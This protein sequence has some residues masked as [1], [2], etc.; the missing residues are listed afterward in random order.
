MADVQQA[1]FKNFLGG[2]AQKMAEE[3]EQ[4]LRSRAQ[5]PHGSDI[6]QHGA[7]LLKAQRKLVTSKDLG[8][9][10]MRIASKLEQIRRT[11]AS[12]PDVKQFQQ[13]ME[14]VR[15]LLR[16]LVRSEQFRSTLIAALK[17]GKHIIEENAEGS[18][19]K[20]LE[21]G[22][23]KGF[24]AAAKEAKSA[25]DK[26]ARNLEKKTDKDRDLISD[27]DWEKLTDE[28]DSLFSRL[29]S[30]SEFRNGIEQLFSLGSMITSEAKKQKD[31]ISSNAVQE[32]KEEAKDLV[33]Q[34]SG[35]KE[36][37]KLFDSLHS[38]VKEFDS[39]K[40]A[41][42]WWNEFKDHT[43]K[44]AKNYHGKDDLNKFRDL[45]QRGLDIFR[46]VRPKLDKLFDRMSDVLNNIANDEYVLK[47]RESLGAISDD[48]Y[49]QDKEGK[50]YIDGDAAGVLLS[51]VS[52]VI[53]NKF[54]HLPLPRI[55]RVEDDMAYTLD[56]LIISATLP[57]QIDFHL[58]SYASVN[59]S[60]M[61]IPGQSSLQTEIYLT[62]AI[63]GIT[64]VAPNIRFTYQGTALSES[65]IMSVR[66]PEPGAD[67]TLEFVMRP[68]SGSEISAIKAPTK[69]ETTTDTSK[70]GFATA[71]GGGMMRYE[72]VKVVSHFDIPDLDIDYDTKTL[73]HSFLVPLITS[74]FKARIV[75]RFED[76]VEQALNKGLETLGQNLVSILNKAEN[77]LSISSVGSS[78]GSSMFTAI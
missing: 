60:Q 36:L 8:D 70:K 15:P 24:E 57:D 22:E 69:I 1:A 7:D 31:A 13:Q 48:L 27:R 59:T 74:L 12:S 32:V 61:G 18:V 72:F 63:R 25:I 67:L 40:E 78:V 66:I 34:F 47:L 49:W 62:A 16:L 50:R 5:G 4:E 54:G 55:Q 76:E 37:D 20:I 65:G 14:S 33:A 23:K 73:S 51:S 39:N 71:V 42:E 58:E 19:D 9:R 30:H 38:L 35:E 75:D 64:A 56:N 45:F 10:F 21:K 3:A 77:P 46:D 2:D 26:T 41:G 11:S 17:V 53:R 44:V 43:L 52:D 6:A 29:Q 68:I 28:L